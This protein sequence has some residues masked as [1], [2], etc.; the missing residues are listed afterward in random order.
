MSR[1]PLLD[2]NDADLLF[3]TLVIAACLA[4]IA[5]GVVLLKL[6]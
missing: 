5:A 6:S 3:W 4:W 1:R 2:L